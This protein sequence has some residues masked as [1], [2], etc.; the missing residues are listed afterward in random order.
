MKINKSSDNKI[1]G[2]SGMVRGEFHRKVCNKACQIK[3][4]LDVIPDHLIGELGR[5]GLKLWHGFHWGA[6]YFT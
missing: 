3:V 5:I 1:I 6:H 4:A 2:V